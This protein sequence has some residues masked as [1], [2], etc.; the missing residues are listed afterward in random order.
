MK[1]RSFNYRSLIGE[2]NP[3]LRYPKLK[4][5]AIDEFAMKRYEDTSLNDILKKAGMSKGSFYHHFGDKFGLYL[6][7]MD[8]I[9]Q[10]K[11]SFFY[12]LMQ[13]N[14]DTG[15]FFGML[16]KIMQATTEFMLSDERMHHLSNRLMEEDEK[17]RDRLYSFF[18]V[19]YY[20]SLNEW[21]YQAVQSGQI[22]SRYPPKFV[23]KVIEIMFANIHKLIPSGD[24][25]DLLDTAKQV[26]DLIQYGISRKHPASDNHQDQS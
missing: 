1:K 15:D 2:G 17:F 22:D 12:P 14:L 25:V 21:V 13:E 8:I 4:E 11:L 23:F 5:T 7:M 16:K 18:G 20:K 26:I 3:L 24:P 10:K 19:D 9:A 6:A